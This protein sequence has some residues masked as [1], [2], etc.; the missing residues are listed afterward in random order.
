M[1]P[2]PLNHLSPCDRLDVLRGCWGFWNGTHEQSPCS[3]Q[4]ASSSTPIENIDPKELT[5]AI[6]IA[7]L[8][9]GVQLIAKHAVGRATSRVSCNGQVVGPAFV[10]LSDLAIDVVS[11]NTSSNVGPESRLRFCVRVSIVTW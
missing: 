3:G 7:F 10:S 8:S 2:A 4:D 6:E 11:R 5:D 9:I 1:V